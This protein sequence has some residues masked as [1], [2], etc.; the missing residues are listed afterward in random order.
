MEES[1][2]DT[3]LG[4][5]EQEKNADQPKQNEEL[6]PQKK[7]L[8]LSHRCCLGIKHSDMD[9]TTALCTL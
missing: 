6:L 5:S 1:E 9:Q 2:R 8:L 4:N 3:E 7:G